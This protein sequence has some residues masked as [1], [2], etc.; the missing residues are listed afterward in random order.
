MVKELAEKIAQKKEQEKKRR[1]NP[2]DR[3]V[4]KQKFQILG[5]KVKGAQTKGGQAREQA[6][7]NV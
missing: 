3:I 6:L 7:K 2:F 5:R 4:T 1:T